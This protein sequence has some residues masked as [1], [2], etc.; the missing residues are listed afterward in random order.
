[1]TVTGQGFLLPL[2]ALISFCWRR[3]ETVSAQFW[4][5]Q[6][7]RFNF[8]GAPEMKATRAVFPICPVALCQSCEQQ[9]QPL[10]QLQAF[11]HVRR[12]IS[13]GSGCPPPDILRAW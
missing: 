4:L 8:F 13:R 6:D 7:K 12:S 9:H 10:G 11:G 1:M 3:V 2:S 5:W